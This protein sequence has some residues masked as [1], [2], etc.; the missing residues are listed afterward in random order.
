ME[1]EKKMSDSG[2]QDRK[3]WQSILLKTMPFKQL[4][5]NL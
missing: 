5:A 3:W 4:Y 2:Q 1:K